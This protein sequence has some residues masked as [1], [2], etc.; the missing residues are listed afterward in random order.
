MYQK[1]DTITLKN[2]EQVEAGVVRGPDQEW[3]Q[4]LVTLLW[5][6]GDPWNWQN[7]QVLERDLGLD[8]FFYVLHRDGQPLANIMTIECQGVGHFGHVWTVPED[9]QKG[10]SSALMALQ[11]G[12]FAERGGQA[13]FLGT[14]YDSVPYHMY[15]RFGF[16]GIEPGNGY[17][18]Y[19]RTTQ[20]DFENQYFAAPTDGAD[21]VAQPLTWRH[22]PASAALFLGDFPGLVRCARA[23]LFGRESTEGPMLPLL[24]ETEARQRQGEPPATFVLEHPATQAVVGLASWQWDALWPGVCLVD[25]YCHP[26]YWDYGA[27]LLDALP[28]PTDGRAIAHADAGSEEKLALL[29]NAGFREV[30]RLPQWL[31]IS[32]TQRQMV[33]VLVFQR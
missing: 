11:M 3:A 18:T 9:R 13:L 26:H 17:M 27:D 12:H 20:A 21:M 19:Y 24:L 16:R 33:D 8:A 14:G 30:T 31:S 28:L 1:L 25:L 10:A 4:R 22:W 23:Q 15:A 2:G 29:T 7:A 5:H 32:E 6:K